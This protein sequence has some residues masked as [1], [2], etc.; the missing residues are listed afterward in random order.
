MSKN[1]NKMRETDYPVDDYLDTVSDKRKKEAQI[2]IEI[3]RKITKLEPKM[4]GDSIIG[5]GTE[6]Y[7]Y[8]SGREGDQ[9]LLA[10]SPRKAKLTI[11]FDSG[12]DSHGGDIEK[13]G[14]YKTGV[15]C[16]YIN[17]IEDIDLKVLEKMLEDLY[18]KHTVK[19]PKITSVEEYIENIPENS[20]E[21]FFRLRELIKEIIPSSEEKFSYGIIGYKLTFNR[22]SF[23]ISAW[24]DHIAL[25]PLPKNEEYK[26][27]VKDYVKGKSTIW[28]SLKEDFPEKMLIELIK[29]YNE[30]G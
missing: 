24:K 17:K 26:M 21:Y 29:M 30:E 4:W 1:E 11:Y 9:P 10:F 19:T 14:K 20:A 25:Y 28:I 16:L 2:I 5:F 27:K 12:F 8:E 3:M 22:P 13:L 15:S 23:F 7:I 6:H 18:K